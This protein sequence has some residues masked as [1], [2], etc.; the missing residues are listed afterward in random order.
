MYRNFAFLGSKGEKANISEFSEMLANSKLK[1]EI[2]NVFAKKQTV[3]NP[4]AEVF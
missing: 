3:G 2:A 4:R 1:A